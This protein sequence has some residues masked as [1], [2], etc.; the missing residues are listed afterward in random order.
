MAD[1]TDEDREVLAK[2]AKWM[3]ET[4]G[5]DL[6]GK[7]ADNDWT[8]VVKLH[9][10]IETALNAVLLAELGRSELEPIIAKLETSN[11]ATG[12]VA[13]AKAL[14]IF[15]HKSSPAFIQQ[16]SEL[17]NFCVHDLRNFS[18]DLVEHVEKLRDDKRKA[19]LKAISKEIR[20]DVPRGSL[21]QD[22]RAA[23][24]NVVMQLGLRHRECQVR[25]L[26]AEIQRLKAETL[27]AQDQSTPTEEPNNPQTPNPPESPQPLSKLRIGRP[28]SESE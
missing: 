21:Q 19:L 16:L 28:K 13:F 26:E 14:N 5:A 7:F 18:F 24:M 12:K 1:I 4:L 17:R 27:D 11:M 23:T 15:L 22:L 20:P 6:S 25:D 9:A 8:L 10:M 2:I 3:R